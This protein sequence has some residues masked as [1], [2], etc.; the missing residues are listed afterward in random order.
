ML[1][2]LTETVQQQ[3]T[4]A[5]Q[6]WLH[7]PHSSLAQPPAAGGW[8]ANEC[9]QHL[10]SYSR[11]YLPRLQQAFDKAS[12]TARPV[13]RSWKPGWLGGWF[14]RLMQ[15]DANGQATKKMKAPADHRPASV[16]PSQQVME[17]F[18]AHQQHLLHLLEQAAYLPL[19]Q[20]RIPTSISQLIKLQAGDVLS[21]L[22]AHQQRHV[23]QA[24]RALAGTAV[25]A[26]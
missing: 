6:Q 4:Q 22:V 17:E 2:T 23:A 24:Q 7:L 14:T 9:L 20:L 1:Q 8:S 11:Y 15:P 3:L 21:F 13:Q 19:Q 5:Q 10:N 18:I 25:L 12:A 16:L 26:M